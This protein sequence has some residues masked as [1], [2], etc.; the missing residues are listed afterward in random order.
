MKFRKAAEQLANIPHISR[1]SALILYDF[2]IAQRPADCIE[3]GFAHGAGSGYIAAALDELGAGHLT[4]VDL[5]TSRDFTPTIEHTL[6]SLGLAARVSIHREINSYNWF[7]KKKIEE[8]T[9]EGVCTPC[10]DFVFIDGSKNWTIDGMA[11][12]LADKLLRPGGWILFDDYDWRYADAQA[13]GKTATDGISIRELSADQIE[14]PNVAAIFDLLVVGHPDYANFK[15]QDKSWAWAQKTGRTSAD[16]R[17]VQH[18]RKSALKSK[19]KRW[20]GVGH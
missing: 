6:D 20:T 9:T 14:Q 19:L 4:C 8:Q 16:K 15:V 3:L 5:E 17:L 7:L 13:K 10:Y 18:E 2:L 1:H 12:F 11:F